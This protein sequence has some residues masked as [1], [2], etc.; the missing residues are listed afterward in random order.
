[1]TPEAPSAAELEANPV[2]QAALRAA[3]A[4]SLA[5]DDTLRHEEGGFIYVNVLTGEVVVRRVAPGGLD[6]LNLSHPPELADCFL[7]ATF[8]T[9]P[10]PSALG[11]DPTPSSDDYREADDSGV[12]WLVVTDVG[13][14]IAGPER[15]VG[16]LSGSPGYPF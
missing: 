1:M 2:V 16:G 13:V 14:F 11:W 7:V 12:P 10:N 5:D 9:H 8:H 15:R 6:A 4:D 3:W